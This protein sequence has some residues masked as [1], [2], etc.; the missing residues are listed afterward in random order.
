MGL[1]IIQ[2]IDVLS[3]LCDGPPARPNSTIEVGKIFQSFCARSKGGGGD[4]TMNGN[5]QYI[6]VK[7]G[8]GLGVLVQGRRLLSS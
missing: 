1:P 8:H 6:C 7:F 2:S 4:N 5:W 3:G